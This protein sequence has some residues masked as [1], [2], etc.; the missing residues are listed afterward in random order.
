MIEC[1]KKETIQIE[2]AHI[3]I[4]EGRD[5]E[6]F[7]SALIEDID[8][9][10]I[11]IMPIGGKTKLPFRLDALK[12]T[13]GFETVVSSLGII[14]DANEN[15]NDAFKSVCGALKKVNLDVP[16]KPLKLTKGRPQIIISI[17]PDFTECGMLEDLCLR[18]VEQNPA[19]ICVN[20]YFECL[21]NQ[22]LPLPKNIS[23]AKMH[24]FLASRKEACKRLGEA[25]Q[26]GYFPWSHSSFDHVKKFLR[27]LISNNNH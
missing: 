19:I 10:S 9:S 11:Q 22:G 4:V 14:R 3:L 6:L 12:K 5:E 20:N 26:A 24:V 8:L 7:F 21:K 16:T 15:P 23:K 2:K 25:A 27:L 1:E 17:M 18:A 13:P